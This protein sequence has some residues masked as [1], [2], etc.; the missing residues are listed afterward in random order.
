MDNE[1]PLVS[2][3]IPC[4]NQGAFLAE[5]LDS[6][7]NQK[8]ENW[9][10]LI[11]NDD[12]PDNTEVVAL[13]YCQVDSRFRYIHKENGGV[14]STRNLGLKHAKGRYIQFLDSD[15][16]LHA[17]KLA[18]QVNEFIEDDQKDV[19]VGS[20][21]YFEDGNFNVFYYDINKA[22]TN[23]CYPVSGK[24]A[25]ILKHLFDRN[26]FATSAPLFKK[27]IFDK[28]GYFDESLIYFEDW[29]LWLR[30]AM[31]NYTF[32]SQNY[33]KAITYIRIH[34]KSVSWNYKRM[35]YAYSQMSEKI[36]EKKILSL[37]DGKILL[38]YFF[39]CK[40]KMSIFQYVEAL[41]L[42]YENN[43]PAITKEWAIEKGLSYAVLKLSRRVTFILSLYKYF[44][45][46]SHSLR[47][48]QLSILL[49]LNKT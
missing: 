44:L 19:I 7:L 23:P 42:G 24:G 41:K 16:L 32:S 6:V 14:S 45:M 26:Q 49:G 47:R 20:A 12:S 15:D 2:V 39:S 33:H 31:E 11:V 25:K 18:L 5:T 43:N 21:L 8:Y 34:G 48:I 36:S 30:C 1:L 37:K 27:E 46:F 40:K 28:I 4:Y 10:C 35:M 3:I 13:N 38:P 22:L 17:D 9:E 29:D